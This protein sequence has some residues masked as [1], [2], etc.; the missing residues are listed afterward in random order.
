M[1]KITNHNLI[2][3]LNQLPEKISR[4]NLQ[5]SQDQYS[6]KTWN[7]R[8]VRSGFFRFSYL[9]PPRPATFSN[10]NCVI[11]RA[12]VSSFEKISSKEYVYLPIAIKSHYGKMIIMHCEFFIVFSQIIYNQ[13]VYLNNLRNIIFGYPFT[14]IFYKKQKQQQQQKETIP[15]CCCF[16]F[17]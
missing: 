6:S 8:S 10:S 14:H 3:N 13:L 1:T 4:V 12:K 11:Q 17:L 2:P 15:F 16:F 5:T 7:G 9:L